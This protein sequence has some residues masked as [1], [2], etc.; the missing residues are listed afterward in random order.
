MA[1]VPIVSKGA[2]DRDWARVPVRLERYPAPPG[3]EDFVR[4]YWITS[5]RVPVG[6]QLARQVLAYPSC[7]LVVQS[8]TASLVGPTTGLSVQHLEGS[9]WAFGVLLRPAAGY[10]LTGAPLSALVN[11]TLTADRLPDGDRLS[12]SIRDI[13]APA[14]DA[15]GS[16]S[17]AIRAYEA[18][19]RAL[20]ITPDAQDLLVNQIAHSIERDSELVRVTDVA[21]RFGLERRALERLLAKRVGISPKQLIQ[22]RRLQE[23]AHAIN[24]GGGGDLSR[25]ATELGYADYSHFSREFAA[26]TGKTPAEFRL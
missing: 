16:H 17:A 8:A 26:V 24:T 11:S 4:H 6:A 14:P 3:L 22:R 5:W 20:A 2:I 1:A 19:F 13:V 7:N 23:A 21:R 12:S 9:S 10:R 25:L 18:W 15:E